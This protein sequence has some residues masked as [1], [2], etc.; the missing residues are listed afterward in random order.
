MSPVYNKYFEN[1]LDS[2]FFR[3]DAVSFKT[4]LWDLFAYI[5]GKREIP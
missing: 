5:K 2:L 3:A 4:I 1:N